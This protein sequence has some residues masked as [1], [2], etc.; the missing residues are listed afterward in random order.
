VDPGPR[1]V[2]PAPHGLTE[3]IGSLDTAACPP[4]HLAIVVGGTG[5]EYAL[6]TVNYASAVKLQ[7][8]Y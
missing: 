8:L 3:K 6:K 5:A 4:C 2:H 7:F 1:P